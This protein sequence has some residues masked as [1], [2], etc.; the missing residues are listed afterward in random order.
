MY[1]F[2]LNIFSRPSTPFFDVLQ[3]KYKELWM[4]Q[5][6]ALTAARRVEKK[7]VIILQQHCC[8]LPAMNSPSHPT[9]D[10]LLSPHHSEQS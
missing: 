3:H 2:I 4:E 1:S 7:K 8:L 6:R 5:Q 10:G 9:I